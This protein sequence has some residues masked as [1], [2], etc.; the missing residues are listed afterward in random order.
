MTTLNTY[1]TF[2]GNCELAFNFYKS[3]FGREF[4]HLGKFKDMPEDPKYPISESDKNKVM[5]V[6]LPISGESV[7]MG[8]DTGGEWA[9]TYNQG[10]NFS[11]SIKA[12][13]T[14]EADKLFNGL[15]KDGRII[16]PINKTFWGSY[17][18]MLTDQFGIQW[19]VSYDDETEADS[20]N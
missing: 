12:D 9:S 7:L 3:V 17:F 5:H 1:L 15:S 6:S 16:M 18:G 13:S 8:C 10:S 11:I 20:G 14:Q 2:N 4:A 19:M